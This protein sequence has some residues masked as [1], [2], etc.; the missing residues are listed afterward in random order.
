MLSSFHFGSRTTN[1]SNE[2]N[3]CIVGWVKIRTPLQD[4][5]FLVDFLCGI[6]NNIESS[7]IEPY[8]AADTLYKIQ[9]WTNQ[10]APSQELASHWSKVGFYKGCPQQNKALYENFQYYSWS[11]TQNL[12]GNNCLGWGSGF[13]PTLVQR[14]INF[15]RVFVIFSQGKCCFYTGLSISD[16]NLAKISWLEVLWVLFQW[17]KSISKKFH[18]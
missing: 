10:K 11:Q 6:R 5:Y 13:S 9:L 16:A 1:I 14:Q 15:W 17:Q 7:H 3:K 4:N 18:R 8:F 12:P 2:P